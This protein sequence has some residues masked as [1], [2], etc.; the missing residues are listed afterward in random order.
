MAMAAW[1]ATTVAHGD[2]YRAGRLPGDAAG[3]ERDLLLAELK[4]LCNG[5]QTLFLQ[6]LRFGR[7]RAAGIAGDTTPPAPLTNGAVPAD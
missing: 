2:Q 5:I 3:F 4:C 6:F 7:V 1:D